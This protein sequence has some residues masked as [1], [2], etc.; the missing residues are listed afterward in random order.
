ML[1]SQPLL[2]QSEA[3]YLTLRSLRWRSSENEGA[4]LQDHF[5]Y[6]RGTAGPCAQGDSPVKWQQDHNHLKLRSDPCW[7]SD[8]RLSATLS[9]EMMS[10]W[11]ASQ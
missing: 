7:L 9:K 3:I 8:A 5:A 4:T 10:A 2:P 6:I 1:K 11:G